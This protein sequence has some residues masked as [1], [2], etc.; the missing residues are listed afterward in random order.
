LALTFLVAC[1]S[2]RSEVA[3]PSAGIAGDPLPGL[4]YLE[5]QQFHRGRD[6]F[7][8]VFTPEDGLGPV[9][10]ENQCSACHTDPAAGGTGEQLVLKATRYSP[11]AGCDLLVD[12]GGE[13]VRTRATPTLQASGIESE[14]V[15]AEATET[16]RVNTLFLFGLGM[17]EA[18]PE[19]ALAALADP[20]DEDGD[21]ISGRLGRTADGR[22]ARF[23]SKTDFAT[24]KEF[25][26]GALFMEMGVTNPLH[27]GPDLLNGQ[28]VSPGV[29][30]AS[31][32]EV[33]EPDLDNV[34]AFVR[35]LAP[36][37]RRIPEDPEGRTQVEQG[38]RV[39]KEIGCTSCHVPFLET[40]ES[41][42]AAIRRQP[43]GFYSDF[44]LHDLGPGV[45]GVCGPDASPTE[46]R[47]GIL[48]GVGLREL[49]LHQG[50]ATSLHEALRLHGGEAASTRAAY[51]A[52]PELERNYLLRFLGTL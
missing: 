30:P 33:V 40:G 7:N 48:M 26:A 51:Q 2:E 12:Q 52:L 47:T 13:N 50:K 16:S 10:N 21:G 27:P 36:I 44:L 19:A 46:V 37:A 28:P 42:V 6:F 14:N 23:G 45:E 29:D 9:F 1:Q 18:I 35:F 32:P 8:R 43:V 3:F 22:V 49:F 5:L 31:D 4:S 38:E 20:D 17:A 41:S 15:P 11:D 25:N 24:L 34:T 39:F